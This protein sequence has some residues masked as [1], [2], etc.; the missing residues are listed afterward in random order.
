MH[1][2]KMPNEKYILDMKMKL[3]KA[4]AL[5]EAPRRN[6]LDLPLFQEMS[7][8]GWKLQPGDYNANTGKGKA[9]AGNSIM[10]TG[11]VSGLRL[12]FYPSGGFGEYGINILT[13][14]NLGIGGTYSHTTDTID[15]SK[16]TVGDLMLLIRNEIEETYMLPLQDRLESIQALLDQLV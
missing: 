4:M 5:K 15:A 12:L 2:F 9:G 7:G 3:S 6:V 14:R 16:S 8:S 1:L 13:K 11:P 10:A